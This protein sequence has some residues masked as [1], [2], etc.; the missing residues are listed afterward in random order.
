MAVLN[1]PQSLAVGEQTPGINIPLKMNYAATVTKENV[2]QIQHTVLCPV[3]F[4][5][6]EPI[7]EFTTDDVKEFVIEEGLHQAVVIKFSY[8]KPELHDFRRI[9]PKQFDVKG[10]CNIGQLEF[11]HLLVRFE[12][13]EDYVNFV[14]RS[15]GHINSN[16]DEFF[17]RTFPWT[18]GFDPRIETSKAV[19]WISFPDLPPNYFAKKSLMSIASAVG[20]PLAIDKAMKDRTRPSAARV[21]VLLDLLD[22]HPKKVKISVVDKICGKSNDF[23]QKVIYD[24]LPMYCTCCKHQGHD[25][26][27]CR[28][29]KGRNKN[30]KENTEQISR[31]DLDENCVEQLQGDARQLLNAIRDA[32]QLEDNDNVTKL[33]GVVDHTSHT[34]NKSK[35]KAT[36]T[37]TLAIF[38]GQKP[39]GH[40][41]GQWKE[42][43]DKRVK[44][45]N[46]ENCVQTKT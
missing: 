29:M 24:Y 31:T 39:T 40:V 37:G 22:K 13:Y 26:I 46:N 7:I 10:S 4:E 33:Q 9:F 8:G 41:G 45:V 12:L 3:R 25:E 38:T 36:A 6:G 20:K 5:H 32:N 27:S 28:A 2:R 23:S 44:P 17:F 42:V 18:I 34:Q 21:K 30:A 14:S 15:T 16:G 1:S 35:D 19:V 11:R 43:N